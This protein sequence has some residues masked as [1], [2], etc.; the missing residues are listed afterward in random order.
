VS[1]LKKMRNEAHLKINCNL[2]I[3]KLIAVFIVVFSLAQ[4]AWADTGA[5]IRDYINGLHPTGDIV[6]TF[7]PGTNTV[8]VTGRLSATPS[9]ANYLTLNIDYGV[10]VIW[11]AALAGNPS[12]NFSLINIS[13]GLGTFE[14]RNGGSIENTGA[15]RAI[16]NNSACAV[17]ISGGTVKSGNANGNTIH[18]ASTGTVNVS[19][20]VVQNSANGGYAIYNYNSTYNASSGTV[21]VSGGTVNA[22]YAIYNSTWNSTSGMV[23]ISGGT[24][25]TGTGRAIQTSGGTVT[26][27]GGT[28]STT[29][30]E[31]IYN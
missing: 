25:S 20:G 19:S 28:I 9:T 12:S 27:S 3:R 7:S 5:T 15:G 31:A 11:E 17:N 13:G 21:N 29:G 18:N 22:A 6:A 16:T 10:T 30:G 1:S 4:V 14:V 26:I 2:G 23:N 8:T 24:V